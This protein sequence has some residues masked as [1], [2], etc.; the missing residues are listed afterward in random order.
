MPDVAV[1]V[2]GN[3]DILASTVQL[4]CNVFGVYDRAIWNVFAWD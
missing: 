3:S 2:R 1:F 4:P